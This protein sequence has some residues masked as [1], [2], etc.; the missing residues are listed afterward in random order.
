MIFILYKCFISI[1]CDNFFSDVNL[2]YIYVTIFLNN[3]GL[4]RFFRKFKTPLDYTSLNTKS[5]FL[6]WSFVRILSAWKSQ[7]DILNPFFLSVIPSKTDKITTILRAVFIHERMVLAG[8]EKRVRPGFAIYIAE[9]RLMDGYLSLFPR[10]GERIF[11]PSASQHQTMIKYERGLWKPAQNSRELRALVRERDGVSSVT[12]SENIYS[13]FR[14][15]AMLSHMI[16]YTKGCLSFFLSL[17]FAFHFLTPILV[18]SNFYVT[19]NDIVSDRRSWRTKFCEQLTHLN[20]NNSS[21][22]VWFNIRIALINRCLFGKFCI[23]ILF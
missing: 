2:L 21:L 7:N 5:I 6:T 22:F 14:E 4:Q 9:T 20:L 3:C 8:W 13:R 17:F 23:V 19:R 12:A 15:H 1:K 10:I 16:H 18:R 11:T